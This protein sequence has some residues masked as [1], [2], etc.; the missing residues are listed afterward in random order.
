[1]KFIVFYN[2]CLRSKI[3]YSQFKKKNKKDIKAVIKLPINISSKN[4]FF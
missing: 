2:E 3:I 4:K 1:M